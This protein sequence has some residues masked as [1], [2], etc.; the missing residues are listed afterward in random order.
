MLSEKL[1]FV[2]EQDA[3]LSVFIVAAYGI[4][5]PLAGW[6]RLSL[7]LPCLL[8]VPLQVSAGV[9]ATMAALFIAGILGQ[10]NGKVIGSLMLIGLGL[11]VA[12]LLLRPTRLRTFLEHLAGSFRRIPASDWWWAAIASA[13]GLSLLLAPLR[14]PLEWDE[15]MYHLPHARLWAHNGTL[16]VN[17]WLRYPLFPY[18]MELLYGAALV[19]GSDV[20]PHLFHALTGALTAVLTF[21]VARHFLDWRVGLVAVIEL[22]RA[23]KWGWSNAYIDLGLMLFLSSAFVSL[24]LRHQLGDSR[25]SYLAAFFAGIAAGIKYQALFYLPVFAILAL[26]VERRRAVV[27]RA[28]LIFATIGSYWYLRNWLVSGD[29]IHPIG[30]HIFG[31]WLW[32]AEDLAGQFG[33]L[34]RVKDWP[35]WFLLIALGAVLFWRGSTAFIRGLILTTATSVSIWYLASGYSRYLV[36]VYPML[37]MLSSYAIL[38]LWSRSGLALWFQRALQRLGPSLQRALLPVIF[39]FIAAHALH[40]AAKTLRQ[41][42]PKGDERDTFLAQRFGGYALLRSLGYPP[43]GTLYQL[44]FEGELYYLGESVRGDWFGQGRYKDSMA[45]TRDA[46]ALAAHLNDLGA[47]SLLV[48]IGRQPF[49]N[50]FWDPRLLDYFEIVGRSDQAVLYRLRSRNNEGRDDPPPPSAAGAGG[51]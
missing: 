43:V 9:G 42:F 34:E 14:V 7:G 11:A 19:F 44:G 35:N 29:P 21:A 46:A 45:L 47:D 10:F 27:A 50:L 23:T 26:A 8:T 17:H 18:N 51:K 4:G 49:S 39:A 16:T 12:P 30:G 38:E 37:A 3:L 48:N 40:D 2:L 5:R 20:L 25:F 22:L 36:P 24:A 1:L 32:N 15:L 28:T 13:A 41:I 6:M 31:F 33:D